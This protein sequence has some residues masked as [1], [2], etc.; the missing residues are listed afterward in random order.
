MSADDR[1][2]CVLPLSFGY[3][4]YQL[5]PCVRVGATLVLEPGSRSRAGSFRLLEHERITG[6]PGVPTIFHVLTSPARAGRAGAARPALPH[7]RR[8]R[9]S[10]G[11]GRE[12]SAAPSRTPR[13]TSMYGLTECLRVSYLPPD[14]ARR[15]PTSVGHPDPRDRGLG[16]GRGRPRWRL[17]RGRRAA[18]SAGRTSCRATGAIRSATAERLRPGPL[19]VGAGAGD[20]RPVPRATRSGYLHFVGPHGRHDQVAAARRSRPREVE[21][22][23]HALEGVREARGRRESTTRCSARRSTLTWRPSRG[24]NSMR[25][26]C[27]GI[28]QG[29]SRITRSP[30]A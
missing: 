13:S 14:A 30:S 19:A 2:L 20:R 15:R 25:R 8:G 27:G 28:A 12:A 5:L 9:A 6:M 24:P 10:G 11:D 7:Q 4:L 29:G 22:V 16:R 17:G 26:R 18:S 1:V 23:L 3:G 21:E